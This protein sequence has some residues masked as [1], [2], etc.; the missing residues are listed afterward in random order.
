MANDFEHVIEWNIIQAGSE[1]FWGRLNPFDSDD[2]KLLVETDGIASLRVAEYANIDR[3]ASF[4]VQ[5][6]QPRVISMRD[7]LGDGQECFRLGS[8]RVTNETEAP[9][10]LSIKLLF[11]EKRRTL[12]T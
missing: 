3:T 8:I 6:K 9:I 7:C 5:P 4:L 2:W 11:P 12:E 10:Y 1:M